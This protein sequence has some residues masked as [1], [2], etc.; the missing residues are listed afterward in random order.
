MKRKVSTTSDS[1]SNGLARLYMSTPSK[2]RKRANPFVKRGLKTSSNLQ[3]S[4]NKATIVLKA[5]IKARTKKFIGIPETIFGNIMGKP[6]K[7]KPVLRQ[8]KHK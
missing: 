3:V 8:I 7:K 4:G 1:L 6:V 2:L 5:Q